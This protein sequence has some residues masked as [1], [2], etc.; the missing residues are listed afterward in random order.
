MIAFVKTFACFRVDSFG[1]LLAFSNWKL[2]YV[3]VELSST[4]LVIDS[5][6]SIIHPYYGPN[7]LKKVLTYTLFRDINNGDFIF[8]RPHDPFLVP[9]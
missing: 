4:T 3:I 5:N 1:G 2:N 7:N 8:V 9:I 6:D